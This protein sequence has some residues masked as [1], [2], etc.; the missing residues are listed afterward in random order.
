MVG[1]AV[2]FPFVRMLLISK[3]VYLISFILSPHLSLYCQWYK[4]SP[5]RMEIRPRLHE[6]RP[7]SRRP[8]PDLRIFGEAYFICVIRK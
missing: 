2:H 4:P 3:R 7:I 1:L 5:P 8:F 6:V